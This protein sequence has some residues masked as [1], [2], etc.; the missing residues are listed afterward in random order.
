VSKKLIPYGRQSLDAADI[1]AVVKTLKSAWLTQGPAV[2]KFE[3]AFAEY[4]GAPY[5]VAVSNGTAGLHLAA[6]AAGVGPGDEAVTS[7][8][9]FVATANAYRYCGAN[10][11]FADVDDTLCPDPVRIR[12]AMT[13]KT[14]AVSL[15]HF[16]GMPST[17]VKNDLSKKKKDFTLVE[18]AC[19]ALGAEVRSGGRWRRVGDCAG[20]DMAVFSFHP[21]KHITTGEGGM[22]TTRR[23]DLYD[24]LRL[25]RS[26][27]IEKN[28]QK[29][30]GPDA[31]KPWYYEMQALGFNYRIT[32]IQCALGLSQLKKIGGFVARRRAIAERYDR[33][34]EGMDGVGVPVRA[35]DRTSS[36]HL[37]TLR[38]DFPHFC[39]TRPRVMEALR[40]EGIGTQV[41]YIPV[42]RQPYYR[43]LGARPAD[44][45]ETESY[46]AQALSIPLFPAMSDADVRRVA[47]AVRR[48]LAGK[49][50]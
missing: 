14:K 33:A 17:V 30:S 10:V 36:Y 11:R 32:D 3:E 25:L 23:K 21:V 13:A 46:Y 38:I 37:Y 29:T 40:K 5:A 15:V 6:L 28:P 4:C 44:Y 8:M 27:G 22:I 47:G 39:T 50:S 35:E 1:R 43:A 49:T 16:G 26:H 18:D 19:H 12:R 31:G 2:E 48:V 42:T 41:H 9:T 20:T 34:F 45:P 7:P 24:K